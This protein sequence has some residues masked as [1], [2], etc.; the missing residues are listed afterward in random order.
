MNN[1]NQ[2]QTDSEP[3]PKRFRTRFAKICES[4]WQSLWIG[5][6]ILGPDLNF[7][8]FC[9]KISTRL[10]F[11]V[12]CLL[13]Y[14]GCLRNTSSRYQ[15]IELF[16]DHHS[17][18]STTKPLWPLLLSSNNIQTNN[19]WLGALGTTISLQ[20]LPRLC[21]MFYT[22][23]I[24]SCMYITLIHSLCYKYLIN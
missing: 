3:E 8:H 17:T 15:L 5:S 11:P 16:C 6:L 2:S 19:Q 12:E 9:M 20:Y 23:R 24:R 13:V 21:T 22:F 14:W 1:L 10:L 4:F 7:S 18:I